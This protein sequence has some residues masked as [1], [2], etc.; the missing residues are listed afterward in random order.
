MNL[1]ERLR[2]NRHGFSNQEDRKKEK[3]PGGSH[4]FHPP[5][6]NDCLRN[7]S[8]AI[9]GDRIVQVIDPFEYRNFRNPQSSIQNWFRSVAS[10]TTLSSRFPRTFV[11]VRR[12]LVM[13]WVHSRFEPFS[14]Y[15][16]PEFCT[17]SDRIRDER[18]FG[19]DV[20]LRIG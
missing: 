13:Y 17:M 2:G 3:Y 6:R 18:G 7:L 15:F 16:T 5:F 19:Q 4:V 10:T 12:N 20:N 9:C 1:A 11:N 14:Q 8:L